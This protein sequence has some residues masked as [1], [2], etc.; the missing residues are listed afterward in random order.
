MIT[1]FYLLRGRKAAE[2]FWIN[3]AVSSGI[4]VRVRLFRP[5][6]SVLVSVSPKDG[7]FFDIRNWDL[8]RVIRSIRLIKNLNTYL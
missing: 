5:C 7:A 3:E 1:K 8:F 2:I 6:W 4:F